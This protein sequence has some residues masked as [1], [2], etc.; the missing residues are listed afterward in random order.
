MIDPM[1]FGIGKFFAEL[2]RYFGRGDLVVTAPDKPHRDSYLV[3]ILLHI[4]PDGR[5]GHSQYPDNAMT[6]INGFKNFVNQLLGGGFGVVKRVFYL[7]FYKII[8]PAA[9]ERAAKSILI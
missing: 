4:V 8:A 6:V 1:Q 5:F 9:R 3:K 2:N 7:F